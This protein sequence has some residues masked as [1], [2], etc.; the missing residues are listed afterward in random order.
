MRSDI[1]WAAASSAEIVHGV[2]CSGTYC[3]VFNLLCREEAAANN[4]EASFGQ[5]AA[6]LF[7]LEALADVSFQVAAVVL[8]SSVCSMK[9]VNCGCATGGFSLEN[10]TSGSEVL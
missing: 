2:G 4:A 3:T 1:Q 5:D 6:A 10:F 7:S 9:C 8:C